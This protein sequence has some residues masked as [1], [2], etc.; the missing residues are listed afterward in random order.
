MP[1]LRITKNLALFARW[2]FRSIL[3]AHFIALPYWLWCTLE[4]NRDDG[5]LPWGLRAMRCLPDRPLAVHECLRRDAKN[6]IFGKTDPTKFEMNLSHKWLKENGFG[7]FSSFSSLFL[8][9]L[10][11]RVVDY[12]GLTA[13][14]NSVFCLY[15]VCPLYWPTLIRFSA[16]SHDAVDLLGAGFAYLLAVSSRLVTEFDLP[17]GIFFGCPL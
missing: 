5:A 8:E 9:F 13:K 6:F 3:S 15:L 17:P 10:E 7:Q 12:E 1:R 4:F 16:T 14:S 2:I 11:S